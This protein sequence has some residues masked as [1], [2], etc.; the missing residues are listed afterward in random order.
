MAT[1]SASLGTDAEPRLDPFEDTPGMLEVDDGEPD[2]APIPA[3]RRFSQ[4]RKYRRRRAIVLGLLLA[5]IATLVGVGAWWYTSGRYTI[6]PN[7]EGRTVAEARQLLDPANLTLDYSEEYSETVATGK[8]ISAKPG[9]DERV[10]KGTEVNAVVSKGAERL[11]MP[12][13]LNLTLEAAQ[14]NITTG[15]LSVGTVTE[16]Y[17][18]DETNPVCKDFAAG[19]I[20]SAQYEQGAPLPRNTTVD[21]VVS[22][23]KR[24]IEVRDF[25]NQPIEDAIAGLTADGF[26]P[27]TAEPE[28]SDS[29]PQGMVIAQEPASGNASKGDTITLRVSRG[30]EKTVVPA[31]LVNSSLD[32]ATQLLASA[33]L[34]ANVVYESGDPAS[35]SGQVTATDPPAGTE[36]DKGTTVTLRIG[37]QKTTVPSNLRYASVSNATQALQSAGLVANVVYESGDPATSLGLVTGVDPPSGTELDRGATVTLTVG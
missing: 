4:E 9:A 8:I 33:G 17:S 6:V 15:N 35:S 1:S 16:V 30:K 26:N 32:A 36:V 20:C 19:L 22:L 25:T 28:F 18:D 34:A 37:K 10:L 31:N 13:V 14:A 7:I 27:V 24:P 12:A 29:V 11:P 5:I 23:G 2:P 21:L 3:S